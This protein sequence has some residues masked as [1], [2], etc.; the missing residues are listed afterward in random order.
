ME[1]N[2]LK[3]CFGSKIEGTVKRGE[4]AISDTTNIKVRRGQQFTEGECL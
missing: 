4:R 1:K 2:N 3:A